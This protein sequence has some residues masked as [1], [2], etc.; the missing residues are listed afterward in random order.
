[1]RQLWY[2]SDQIHK[3]WGVLTGAYN[4]R[5][6]AAEWGAME[7]GDRCYVARSEAAKLHGDEFARQRK[8][9]VKVAW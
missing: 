3:K 4:Y 7:P 8:N 6:D 9:G 5:E 2:P 1:M